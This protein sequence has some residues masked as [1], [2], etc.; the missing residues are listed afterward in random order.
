[1]FDLSTDLI[2]YT[3]QISKNESELPEFIFN[4]L[5]EIRSNLS[6]NSLFMCEVLIDYSWEM[7]NTNLWCFVDNIWRYIYGYAMLYK[8]II[9]EDDEQPDALIKLCDLGLLMS[10]P[11]LEKQFN[12]IIN[13][14][15][16]SVQ[17]KD[18]DY[19]V[20]AK[21]RKLDVPELNDNF[22]LNIEESPSFETFKELYFDKKV[23]VIID[24]QM[25]HWPAMAKWR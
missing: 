12:H 23:P 3:K 17:T 21:M 16:K 18:E 8:I 2:D 4:Y 13:Y 10:G 19:S 14:L 22:K 20:K 15:S 7:L 9:L 11:L 6:R 25:K 24:G 1:M 5:D